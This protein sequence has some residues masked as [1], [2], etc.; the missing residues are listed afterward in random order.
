VAHLRILRRQLRIALMARP[1]YQSIEL[2][3]YDNYRGDADSLSRAKL[4][5]LDDISLLH[6]GYIGSA[7]LI[8]YAL[9]VIAVSIITAACFVLIV[10]A[11]LSGGISSLFSLASLKLRSGSCNTEL[12]NINITIHL[13]INFFG[14]IVLGSSNYLQQICASPDLEEIERRLKAKGDLSF[15][16]NSASS[17]FGQRSFSLKVIWLS[18]VVTSVPIHVM[19]N[20]IVGYAVHPVDDLSGQAGLLSQYPPTANQ[21]TINAQEC[22]NYLLS[23][24]AYVTD[25]DNMTVILKS[26]DNA[27]EYMQYAQGNGDSAYDFVPKVDDVVDCYI[28]PVV[29][30]CELTIR[31]FPL[32][33]TAIAVT[34][35]SLIAIIALHRHNHFHK[36]LFNS[37]G[38]MIALGTRRPQLQVNR[39]EKYAFIDGKKGA[40]M[41]GGP[42]HP[43]RIQ[44]VKSLGKLDFAVSVFWW[45]SVIGVTVAGAMMWNNIG[46]GL[47]VSDRLKRFGV[48][49][50]DPST[51]FI[52]GSSGGDAGPHLF[53][54]LVLVANSPQLWLSFG[55]LLWN[56]QITRIWMEQEWRS[57]YGRLHKPRVSYKTADRGLRATRWLQLPYWATALLMVIN[58]MLHWLV[59]QT[60]F[61]VEIFGD[62]NITDSDGNLNYS[63]FYINYS[64]LAIMSIGIGSSI[65][66][67]SITIYYFI[68]RKSLMPLMGGSAKLVFESCNGLSW[69]LPKSGVAWG[70]ISTTTQ[71]RAGFGEMVSPLTDGVI[72]PSAINGEGRHF[73]GSDTRFL[74]YGLSSWKMKLVTIVRI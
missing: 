55:Y 31:W 73:T 43:Q 63:D 34:I 71:Y 28:H 6:R 5:I 74:R 32:L 46:A 69:P 9:L 1:D 44:W 3:N 2:D 52:P 21:T 22:Y 12:R 35:K 47:S 30:Q 10:T 11:R 68:P 48:G 14:T 4:D 59:S 42:F 39:N 27:F 65:L 36:R 45:T 23:S 40:G 19:L 13:L 37:L 20:G 41:F 26:S 64:P 66:V 8:S 54:I 57:Y 61:V 15:G 70:D 24:S 51:S 60:M 18:F 16:A 33:M 67:L 38:D 17:V 25:Y 7:L 49:T 56:N 72:Y 29:S 53:P 50:I 62:Q 58:T